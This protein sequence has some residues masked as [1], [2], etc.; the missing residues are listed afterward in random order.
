M[1][2][3]DARLAIQATICASFLHLIS[4]GLDLCFFNL[5]V[6]LGSESMRWLGQLAASI[7]PHSC[8]LS[9]TCWQLLEIESND[10]ID[11]SWPI[12]FCQVSQIYAPFSLTHAQSRVIA[13]RSS[14]DESIMVE[15]SRFEPI[16]ALAWYLGFMVLGLFWEY[17][18][19]GE[20]RVCLFNK[21]FD[22]FWP[23]S[24]FYYFDQ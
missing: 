8:N 20:N 15:W 1:R 3:C 6:T 19:K 5:I 9:D 4:L 10:W 24:Q 14:N 12:L 11:V 21:L 2:E 13:S 17:W 16:W 23:L 18:E 7:C 22:L